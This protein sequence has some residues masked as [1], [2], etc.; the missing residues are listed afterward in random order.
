[1]SYP[2][3][4]VALTIFAPES[5]RLQP[6]DEWRLGFFWILQGIYGCQW[7]NANMNARWKHDNTCIYNVKYHLIWCT[8]YRRK[9]L[10]DNISDRLKDLLLQKSA[11]LGVDIKTMEVM[12]DHVHLF[13]SSTPVHAPHFIIGQLK[14]YTSRILR[15]EFSCLKSRIPTLWT[16]SYYVES[17]GHISEKTVMQYIENQKNR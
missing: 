3:N 12:S 7:Y 11:D 2:G 15:K 4:P 13:V 9:V 5:P 14:G 16:R 1:L 8:K 17:V 10:V 6:W